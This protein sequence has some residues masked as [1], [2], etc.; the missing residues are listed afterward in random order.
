LP[1]A[2]PRSVKNRMGRSGY[3]A[4]NFHSTNAIIRTVPLTRV[5]RVSALD[6]L[7]NPRSDQ[8]A[9]IGRR[10]LRRS[11]ILRNAAERSQIVIE[12]GKV[13]LIS[14]HSR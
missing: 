9:G 12:S 14:R 4:R 7:S 2:K 6:H 5:T 1:A 8:P 10:V 3:L 13:L 11:M